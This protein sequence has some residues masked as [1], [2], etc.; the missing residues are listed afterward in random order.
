[1]TRLN[2]RYSTDDP[3]LNARRLLVDGATPV[4]MPNG[5]IG[6][7]IPDSMRD[8]A[9]PDEKK[10]IGYTGDAEQLCVECVRKGWAE[11]DETAEQ[12]LTRAALE[13]GVNRSDERT[14]DSAELPKPLTLHMI[15]A[16]QQCGGCYEYFG[17]DPEDFRRCLD[18]NC[19]DFVTGSEGP[20]TCVNCGKD[21][22]DEDFE[23]AEEDE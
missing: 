8:Y 3:E 14:Y 23:N 22:D 11:G 18:E 21:Y 7:I 9:V 16:P 19:G 2:P 20:G 17:L 4:A 15:A 10:I 6:L 5:G 1:M 12:A 13:M